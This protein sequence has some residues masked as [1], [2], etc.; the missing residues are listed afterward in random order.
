M[1]TKQFIALVF[2]IMFLIA[3]IGTGVYYFVSRQV[4]S[5]EQRTIAPI[6]QANQDMATRLARFME[7]T[8]TIVPDPVS[9]IH[10]IRSLARL[11]TIQYSVEKVITADSGREELKALFG[12][13]LLFVAHGEV[14][15]GIN[16]EKI[17]LDDVTLNGK[18]VTIKLPE[19]E[20][21]VSRLNNEESYVYD[22]QTGVLV[23]QDESL[24]TKAR[25][26]AEQEIFN[27]A[28]ED[29]ILKQ[30]GINAENYIDRLVRSLG[31]EEVV[32]LK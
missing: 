20:V 5:I 19:P 9:I 22:R 11:E 25:Q 8:A 2:F 4:Q 23:R 21:L 28:I 16:L 18:A 15:A 17:R 10:E 6:Q 31:Y 1:K 29:G 13:R 26:M 32:F 24:E 3:G 30:A 12:D 14:I 27:A 7:P